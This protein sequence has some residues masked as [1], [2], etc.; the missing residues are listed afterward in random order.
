MINRHR[1][2]VVVVDLQDKLLDKIKVAKTVVQNTAKAVQAADILGAPVLWTEQYPK[3]LGPTT[4]AIAQVMKDREP[5][6]KTAFGCMGDAGFTSALNALGRT[7]LL[8][9]GVETH[10]CIL[11]TALGAL[12]EGFEVFVAADAVASRSKEQHK[13]GLDRMKHA[14]VEVVTLEMALFEMLGEA[15][16][17]EFKAMLPL[18]K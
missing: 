6:A 14:G 3:G 9:T 1:C 2:V 4:K 11:Q 18:I 5:M 16:S 15:G 8:I 17:P 13:A 7:Q 12:Q 10:V